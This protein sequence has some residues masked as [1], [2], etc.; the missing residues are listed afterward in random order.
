ML[1]FGGQREKDM[2]R[3]QFQNEAEECDSICFSIISSRGHSGA[4]SWCHMGIRELDASLLAQTTEVPVT[5]EVKANHLSARDVF[6]TLRL[7]LVLR[8][9]M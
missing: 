9:K 3:L 1:G 2:C 8:H 7:I 5:L 6:F 4:R